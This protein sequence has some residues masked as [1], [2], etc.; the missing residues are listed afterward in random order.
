MGIKF[1]DKAKAAAH[2]ATDF[3]EMAKQVAAVR[4]TCEMMNPPVVF[5]HNDLLSGNIMV[6]GGSKT[7]SVE[8]MAIKPLQFI[9]FEYGCY[10]YRGFDWGTLLLRPHYHGT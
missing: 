5:C 1:E 10:S 3:D 8:D 2:K 4:K 6:M 7:A 9:D